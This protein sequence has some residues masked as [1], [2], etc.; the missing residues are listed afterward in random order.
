MK[1]LI[2]VLLLVGL[3]GPTYATGLTDAKAS[4]IAKHMLVAIDRAKKHTVTLNDGD[5]TEFFQNVQ[6]PLMSALKSWPVDHLDNRAIFPY[7]E[8]RQAATDL[9]QVGKVRVGADGNATWGKYISKRFV[10][11][12]Q[13]CRTSIK[14]PDLSLKD[15]Q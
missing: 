4:D 14:N 5:R 6:N 10:E 11:S 13:G 15:I 1:K 2:A 12:Y 9:I 8:C 7:S 3:V